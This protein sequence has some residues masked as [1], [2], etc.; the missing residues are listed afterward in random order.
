[1]CPIDRC[2]LYIPLVLLLHLEAD[3]PGEW[4]RLGE[5]RGHHAVLHDPV[6]GRRIEP[7]RRGVGVSAEGAG[8]RG[9]VVH[10]VQEGGAQVL[11]ELAVVEQKVVAEGLK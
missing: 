1:M 11:R 9:L 2:E 4:V 8:P 10:L 7:D 5:G 3:V 6:Q